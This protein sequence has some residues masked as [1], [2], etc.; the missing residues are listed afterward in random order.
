MLSY[1]FCEIS[2]NTFFTEH[3]QTTAPVNPEFSLIKSGQYMNMFEKILFFSQ[4]LV[5]I[6][7]LESCWKN[8]SPNSEQKRILYNIIVGFSSLLVLREK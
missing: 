2:K 1:G 4:N 5:Y 6:N 3:A 7:K 8:K